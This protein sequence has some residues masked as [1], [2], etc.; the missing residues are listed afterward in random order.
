[1]VHGQQQ[2]V[3]LVAPAAAAARS[4]RAAGEV[5]GRWPPRSPGEARSLRAPLGRSRAR[6]ITGSGSGS[7]A[8]AITC[9][10]RPSTAGKVVRRASWRRT[11]S[12]R[13]LERARVERRCS[14]RSAAML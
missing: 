12:F 13:A 4:E 5:E 8:G 11:I 6:S 9:T 1:M 10:G 2:D 7:S 3:L 14:A